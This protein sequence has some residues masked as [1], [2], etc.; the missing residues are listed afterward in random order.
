MSEIYHRQYHRNVVQE[1]DYLIDDKDTD[2]YSTGHSG[3]ALT[4]QL[5]TSDGVLNPSW[6]AQIRSRGNAT[7]SFSGTDYLLDL[8]F[9]SVSQFSDGYQSAHIPPYWRRRREIWGRWFLPGIVL[10]PNPP[11]SV[12]TAVTNRCIRSFISRCD[13]VRSSFEAGQDFGEYKETLHSIQ[14]PMKS[15]R[16]KT[17][18]YLDTLLR[19]KRRYRSNPISLIKALSDTYLEWHFGIK[20]LI[21][22]VASAVADAKRFRFSQYSVSASASDRYSYVDKDV[23]ISIGGTGGSPIITGIASTQSYGVYSVRYKGGINSGANDQS[24][25]SVAQAWQLYPR[26]WVPTA[27]DLVPY[28]W[29][30]DYFV[31]VGDLIRGYSF[32]F[33]DL[34]WGVKTVRQQLIRSFQIKS[35]DKLA[36]PVSNP[37][38]QVWHQTSEFHGGRGTYNIKTVSRSALVG[39]DLIPR[40]QFTVPGSK[41]PFFNIAA[42]LSQRLNKLVPFF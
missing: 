39:S 30:V 28:S 2:L 18:S 29:L 20:P 37:P 11:T 13:S 1:T 6:R 14:S 23:N 22:D 9:L 41:Y 12:V 24:Q 19:M 33:S 8:E 42:V 26:N 32:V 15:L 10:P 35:I 38:Y 4:S 3:S 21:E 5:A 31:N 40:V 17:V 16:D 34:T 27:W 7:T 25:I 36:F